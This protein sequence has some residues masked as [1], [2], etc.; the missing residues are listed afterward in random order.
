L[1]REGVSEQY[2]L[3]PHPDTP[4]VALSSIAVRMEQVSLGVWHMEYRARGAITDV[5]WPTPA[6]ALRTDGLWA[7]S[8]FELFVAATE[9]QGYFEYNF[10]PSSAWAAYRFSG[11]RDGMQSYDT[12]VPPVITIHSGDG[13]FALEARLTVMIPAK[14]RIGISAVVEETSGIKSYWALAHPPGAPDFHHR[15]CFALQLEAAGAS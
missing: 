3:L 11:Y 15:D 2:D 1:A 14:V 7:H 5:R 9:G 8:C 4:C 13:D 10:S 6:P 12:V